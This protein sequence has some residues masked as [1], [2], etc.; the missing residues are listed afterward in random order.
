MKRLP[1]APEPTVFENLDT[2]KFECV[3]P[4]CGGACCKNGRPP[5]EHAE[6]ARV[7]KNLAK[8]LPHVRPKARRVIESRGFMTRRVK[9]G[10]HTAAVSEG[11]CVFENGGCV[12]HK[13]GAEEGDAWKYKPWR[14]V[15]FPLERPAPKE[16]YVRQWALHGEAWDIFCLNPEESDKTA[17]DT[18]K[19]EAA[20][21]RELDGG[22][23]AWRNLGARRT[24][25][26][27]RGDSKKKKKKR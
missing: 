15:A 21:V 8:F 3:Y 22:K 16:A 27:S 24:P 7:A 13:V 17:R 4:T 19:A 1:R 5:L 26:Q 12:L 9:D 11:W 10:L 20:F 6:E 23:E 18:L 2:A 25:G 14:C